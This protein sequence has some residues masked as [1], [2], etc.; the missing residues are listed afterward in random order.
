MYT[1]KKPPHH[2]DNQWLQ[3]KGASIYP[4]FDV[5][6]VFQSNQIVKEGIFLL[7]EIS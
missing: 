1:A 4:A 3:G 6:N 5:W 7:V 2:F